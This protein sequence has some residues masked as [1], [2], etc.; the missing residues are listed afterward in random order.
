MLA[1]SH[2]I[3]CRVVAELFVIDE[4]IESSLGA[5][6]YEVNNAVWE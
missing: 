2:S 5:N 3:L 4:N 1:R 6:I